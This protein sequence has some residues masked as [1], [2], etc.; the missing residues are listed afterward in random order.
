MP[1]QSGISKQAALAWVFGIISISSL[2]AAPL[3]L[4]SEA[5]VESNGIFLNEIVEPTGNASLS[6]I[7]LAPAP[8]WGK[9]RTLTRSDV[10]SLISQ[11][12]PLIP[13][14][15]IVGA[16]TINITRQSRQLEDPELVEL[17][18]KSLQPGSDPDRDGILGLRLTRWSPV[19]VPHGPINLTVIDKPATGLAAR[20]AVRFQLESGGEPI[21]TYTAFVE[22]NLIREVWVAQSTIRRGTRLD[23]AE[24]VR[25]PR[26]VINL[27]V[28][29]WT[30]TILDPA[31][32]FGEGVPTGAIVFER[33]VRL[34]PVIK[35]N[36]HILAVVR[37]KFM[38]ISAKVQALQDGAPGDIIRARN[39]LTRR[40][41]QG[42]VID[43]KTIQVDL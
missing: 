40:E 4:L 12:A 33:A 42:R 35:R 19:P 36:D 16:E 11:A 23:D 6:N 25:Q 41:L 5:S 8:R 17:L 39:L 26:D 18:T 43:E 7:Q 20:F 15:S 38:S 24:I 9:A 14:N 3:V 10:L 2:Q 34:R 21:G 22:A 31:Y 13:I 1:F 32:H 37:S 30:D 28:R 27:R 29:A